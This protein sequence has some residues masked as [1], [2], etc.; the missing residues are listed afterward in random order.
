M[1]DS[2]DVEADVAG[3]ACVEADVGVVAADEGWS[4]DESGGSSILG[5]VI[6]GGECWQRHSE[7]IVNLVERSRRR[8]EVG[9]DKRAVAASATVRG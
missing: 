3:V 2:Y 9:Y 6:G 8:R 4:D 1:I 7:R 5:N